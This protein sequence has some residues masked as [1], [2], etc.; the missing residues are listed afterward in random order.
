MRKINRTQSIEQISMWEVLSSIRVFLYKVKNLYH[1]FK[2]SF[3]PVCIDL[4]FNNCWFLVYRWPVMEKQV[5]SSYNWIPV[6]TILTTCRLG[7]SNK[8]RFATLLTQKSNTKCKF[9]IYIKLYLITLLNYY[10]FFTTIL[11]HT[12]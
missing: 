9:T 7:T 5:Y 4:S 6:F 3:R 12:V 1:L 11:N 2:N 8:C 10:L